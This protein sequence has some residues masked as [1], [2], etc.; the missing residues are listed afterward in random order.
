MIRKSPILYFFSFIYFGYFAAFVSFN[1]LIKKKSVIFCEDAFCLV[2]KK[3]PQVE[4]IK[5]KK[6]HLKWE[7]Y[8]EERK[9][10]KFCWLNLIFLHRLEIY[11]FV[12]FFYCTSNKIHR[13]IWYTLPYI[14]MSLYIKLVPYKIEGL[15]SFTVPVSHI[16]LEGN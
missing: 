6:K 11:L 15:L 12:S 9:I 1:H 16:Q 10:Y 13:I 14:I 8:S 2:W 5:K 4:L 7:M 3:S